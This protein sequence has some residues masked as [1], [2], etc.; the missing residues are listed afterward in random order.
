MDHVLSPQVPDH[1]LRFRLLE[2][3]H[4]V[5]FTGDIE[6]H[7]LELPKF[8]KAATQLETGL[9][10]WLYFLRNAEK[11]DLDA[12]PAAL[13]QPLVR[14]A[15]EE[16]KMLSQTDLER[17]QYEAR[18]KAQLDYNTGLKVARM[19]G[20]E[21]GEKI[22]L[23]RAIHLFERTLNRPETPTEELTALSP[24]D[25]SRLADALQEQFQKQ[26]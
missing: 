24:E 2:T 14:R 26:R 5:G 4:Q 6:F 7:L 21:E 15:L 1:Y 16:L 22:G 12:V 17:E 3:A 25:L 10:I 9:D 8:T 13:E 19:E 11:M 18:R 23:V 20:R